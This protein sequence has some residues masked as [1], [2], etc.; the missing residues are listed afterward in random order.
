MLQHSSAWLITRC[1]CIAESISCW[2][3]CAVTRFLVCVCAHRY[4]V[5]CLGHSL[6]GGVAALAAYL[7]RNTAELR[8]RL[9]LG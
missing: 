3:V 1:S 5:H 8:S 6:G 2:V 4:M 7:L 9:A